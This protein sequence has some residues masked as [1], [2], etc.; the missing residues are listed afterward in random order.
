MR[1]LTALAFLMLITAPSSGW[2]TE[3]SYYTTIYELWLPSPETCKDI[4]EDDRK[5]VPCD[6][7]GAK[8]EEFLDRLLAISY[9]KAEWYKMEDHHRKMHPGMFT[10]NQYRI[11][12]RKG[13]ISLKMMAAMLVD[14]Y[15]EG[16]PLTVSVSS[17][18]V[19]VPAQHQIDIWKDE[20]PD[21]KVD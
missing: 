9:T 21:F 19:L 16:H 20:H 14:T 12:T 1:T 13:F 3:F 4:P 2:A 5:G 11:V 10:G 15:G 17:G 6:D 8:A 7:D 18:T